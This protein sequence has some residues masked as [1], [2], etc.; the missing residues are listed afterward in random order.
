MFTKTLLPDTVR[1]IKLV[2]KIPA[3]KKSC[4]AGDIALALQLG[5]RISVDLDFFTQ[6]DFDEKILERDLLAFPEFNKD[7]VAW[8]TIWGKIGKTKFSLFYYKYPLLDPTV[9]FSGIQ[10]A[11][12]KDI[13]AMKIQALGDRGTKR[14]FVDLY[15]LSKIYS[16]DQML[17][18]Y[19]QK[20]GD[21]KEKL[22]HLLRSFDY[23]EDAEKDP[24]PNLINDLS[25]DKAK[26]YFHNQTIILSK[27]KLGI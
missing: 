17:N 21:L 20:Y 13:A 27:A 18:F 8:K 16:M 1:A 2:S 12:T 19:N 24:M 6:T 9:E 25:W 4:L 7:G 3:V 11:S 23:F 10:L 5:H 26:E 14:D 22:Y 15:F